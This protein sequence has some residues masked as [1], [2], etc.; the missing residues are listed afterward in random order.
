MRRK[1]AEV[2]DEGIGRILA[3]LLDADTGAGDL[4]VHVVSLRFETGGALGYLL[5]FPVNETD[6]LARSH[7]GTLCEAAQLV[8]PPRRSLRSNP[9]NAT[10][11]SIPLSP[12]RP[13]LSLQHSSIVS[14]S[15]NVRS[16]SAMNSRQPFSSSRI[17]L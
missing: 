16:N 12:E 10:I 15:F 8:Q 4:A 3:E 7:N 6:A 5:G 1:P 9:I 2:D 17:G 13:S 14:A 11:A